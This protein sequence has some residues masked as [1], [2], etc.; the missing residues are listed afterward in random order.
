MEIFR[1]NIIP[2][3][4][5]EKR[6]AFKN[7]IARCPICKSNLSFAYEQDYLNNVIIEKCHCESCDIK[8]R[9]ESHKKQ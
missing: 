9:E 4:E 2:Q 6:E 7:S 3:K 8:V 5:I 1:F